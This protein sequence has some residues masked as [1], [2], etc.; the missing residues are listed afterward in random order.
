MSDSGPD[1]PR[2]RHDPVPSISGSG[3][4][5][6][7]LARRFEL[8][9]HAAD[10]LRCLF[11]LVVSDPHA[12]TSTRDPAAV[13]DDHLADSLVALELPPVRDA[14]TIADLGSGAGFP[15][16]P[17]AIALPTASVALVESN[18]RKAAFIAGAISA[19]GVRNARA[20]NARVE[21]WPEGLGAFDL[22]TARALAP[23]AV[24]AEYAA[25]LLRVGGSLVAW[26]G[27]REPRGERAAEEAAAQLGLRVGEVIAVSPYSA[28]EHRH[29]HVF[30][31]LY[32]TPPGFP[33]RP[34][35]AVKRPL[36]GEPASDRSRR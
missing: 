33:R 29:L 4:D 19:C 28:A 14:G 3:S 1:L 27:R 32:E 6:G 7:R 18:G 5:F 26:R 15:G 9:G 13:L 21:A 36:G 25:P 2:R 31:K 22:V 24:L 17:L 30:E 34:G 8:L 23:L 20:V 10:R 16:L 35:I 11:E 12:P